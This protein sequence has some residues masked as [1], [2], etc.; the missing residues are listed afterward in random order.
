MQDRQIVELYW[1]RNE[2]AIEQTDR[3][4]GLYC[5]TV[6]NNILHNDEDSKE[7]VN[8]TWLR[9]WNAMPPNRPTKLQMFLA[10]IT[11]NLALDRYRTYTAE[12]RGGGE[13]PLVL[14]ELETC[15]PALGDVEENFLAKEL[16]TSINRFVRQL[17]EQEGNIFVRRYFF[18]ESISAIADRYGYT[19]NNIAVILSRVRRK[20]KVHLEKEGYGL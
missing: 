12:K 16:S 4:Y 15:I 10:K 6:A 9:A 11:R 2:Q 8:D 7:C 1:Q 5:R 19:H 18:A 20:L 13:I 17:P 14:S 3:K